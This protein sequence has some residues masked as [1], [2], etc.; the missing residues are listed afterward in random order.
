MAPLDDGNLA[1]NDPYGLAGKT[2]FVHRQSGVVRGSSISNSNS[3]GTPKVI[4]AGSSVQSFKVMTEYSPMSSVDYLEIQEFSNGSKKPF[5][6]YSIFSVY[7]GLC[8]Y[9]N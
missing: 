6:F 2:F 7:S 3:N 1:D 9:T 4:D 8:T 5:I